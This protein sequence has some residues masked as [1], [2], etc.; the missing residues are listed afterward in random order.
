MVHT[1]IEWTEVTWNPSTGCTKISEGCRYCYV[2]KMSHRLKAM[3]Q[4][5]YVNDFDLTIHEASLKE[6]YN[7]KKP[8][9]VFVNSM[10][11]LFHED[12]P[13]TFIKKVFAVMNDNPRHIFQV[14]TKRA[15]VLEKYSS[16][17]NRTENI[18][19]G[20]SVESNKHLYS[21]LKQRKHVK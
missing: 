15:D 16:L 14:L 10:S 12:M 9:I 13:L 2:E 17:L 6:P 11:D 4:K 3:G 21:F 20:M 8:Q 1:K 7:W 19:M 18:W 5:K